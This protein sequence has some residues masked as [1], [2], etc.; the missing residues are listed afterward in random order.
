M[1]RIISAATRYLYI[2]IPM[3]PPMA[4]LVVFRGIL[5]GIRHR[6]A[7]LICSSIEMI[8]KIIFA[9]YIVPVHGYIAMCICEPITWVACFVFMCIVVLIN[10]HEL[11][12]SADGRQLPRQTQGV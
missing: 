2:N 5:Q 1:P 8:G 6:V 10:R 12:G 4:V 11:A 7:P 9:F 3:I